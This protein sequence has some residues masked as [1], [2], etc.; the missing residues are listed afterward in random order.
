[1]GLL[2][3]LFGERSPRPASE[4]APP[5]ATPEDEQAI[6][7]YRYLLRTAP[8]EA[9]EEAHAEAFAQ[10]S[11]EQRALA[12]QRLSEEV[13]LTERRAYDPQPDPTTLARLATRAELRRPGTL[14]RVFGGGAAMGGMSMGGT[15]LSSVAGAFIGTTIA[16]HLLG[17]IG[18][19]WAAEGQPGQRDA[20]ADEDEGDTFADVGGPDD[21][22]ADI[23]DDLGDFEV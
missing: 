6:A 8:P 19:P 9:I 18:G 7:G 12:L 2:Q 11:P 17:G 10:L 3:K 14:E 22:G 20:T 15:L 1:M 21:P 4:P 13:P 16:H 23:G 5:A